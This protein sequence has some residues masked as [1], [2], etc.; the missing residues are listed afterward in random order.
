MAVNVYSTSM[1]IENLSRHDMLAWVNDS[2]QLSYTKIEQ[3][4]SG[5]WNSQLLHL[6]KKKKKPCVKPGELDLVRNKPSY[7]VAFHNVCIG[8]MSFCAIWKWFALL[9]CSILPVYGHA[10]PRVYPPEESEVPGQTGAWIH[11]QLQSAP[12]SLQENEC[13]QGEHPSQQA[14]LLTPP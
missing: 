2:L 7:F 6:E 11:P 10:V 14:I 1:T 8:P 13:R 4:C 5:R 12:S 9:R 3:L